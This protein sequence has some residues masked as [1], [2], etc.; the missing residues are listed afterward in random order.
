MKPFS[1]QRPNRSARA[2]ASAAADTGVAKRR[3]A[4]ALDFVRAAHG[5]GVRIAVG[6]DG[7]GGDRGLP[8]LHEELALLVRAGLTPVEALIAGTRTSAEALGLG[9]SHGTIG[10]GKAADL[11]VLQADPLADIRNTR[12][13]DFVVKRG[14]VV[15]K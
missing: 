7:M 1:R 12:Q 10:V 5:A 3:A 15:E 9:A 4:R 14:K 2:R 6:T 13:I 11:L 8:N